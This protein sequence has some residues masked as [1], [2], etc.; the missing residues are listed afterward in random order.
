MLDDVT[1]LHHQRDVARVA[2]QTDVVEWVSGRDDEVGALAGFER[3]DLVAE[4][5]HVGGR[6]GPGHDGVHG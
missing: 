1:V 4:I 5:T 6:A 3:A 2:E